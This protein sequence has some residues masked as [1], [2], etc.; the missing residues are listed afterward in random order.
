M[1]VSEEMKVYIEVLE[2][3]KDSLDP[4]RYLGSVSELLK[5]NINDKQILGLIDE[6]NGNFDVIEGA[7]FNEEFK[8]D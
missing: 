2:K 1:S 3:E 8:K 5:D 4:F 6:I 7:K